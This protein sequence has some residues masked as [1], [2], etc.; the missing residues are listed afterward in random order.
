[1]ICRTLFPRERFRARGDAF[2]LIE[3]LTVIAIILVL[4][5][6]LLNV[7]GSAQLPQFQSP[8]G[9]PKSGQWRLRLESYKADNGTYPRVLPT[10][11][12]GGAAGTSNSD[13]LNAQSDTDPDPA[14][15]RNR[16]T[17]VR[18]RR[19]TRR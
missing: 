3:L 10:S 15:L 11:T 19:F 7:A 12:A 17:R 6:L 13:S 4:A 8:R 16:N 1:M 9:R 2:T 18:A 14:A 5:G